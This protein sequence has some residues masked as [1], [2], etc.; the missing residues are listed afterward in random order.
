[1]C[2]MCGSRE[3]SRLDLVIWQSSY[4][5][6]SRDAPRRACGK[7]AVSLKRLTFYEVL[8][9]FERWGRKKTRE[10]RGGTKEG[11]KGGEDFTSV[12]LILRI[13]LPEGRNERI[14]DTI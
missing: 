2:S 10:E 5:F 8:Q 9:S 13:N 1:M 4:P 14:L 6:R 7:G 3:S 11:R 12:C